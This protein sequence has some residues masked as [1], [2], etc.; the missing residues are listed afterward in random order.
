[1]VGRGAVLSNVDQP[2]DSNLVGCR[3]LSLPAANKEQVNPER[4]RQPIIIQPARHAA[5][6]SFRPASA[7]PTRH[8]GSV[9]S[10]S[11]CGWSISYPACSDSHVLHVVDGERLSGKPSFS[12]PRQR[13]SVAS[14][15]RASQHRT[16]RV[17]RV[18]ACAPLQDFLRCLN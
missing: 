3:A 15:F 12:D 17:R 7:F 10:E 13:R 8:H 4:A 2:L 9:L 14:D 1:M 6:D 16:T 18:V 11:G 5:W